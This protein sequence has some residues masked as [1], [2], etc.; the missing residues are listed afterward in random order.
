MLGHDV[1]KRQHGKLRVLEPQKKQLS[2][3]SD[4]DMRVQIARRSHFNIP[5]SPTEVYVLHAKKRKYFVFIIGYY[6][7]YYDDIR[8]Q[9]YACEFLRNGVLLTDFANSII[10]LFGDRQSHHIICRWHREFDCVLVFAN[11]RFWRSFYTWSAL[12]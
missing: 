2:I 5:F 11:G 7:L 4:L 1:S 10:H 3:K 6:V 9:K 12:L 8:N